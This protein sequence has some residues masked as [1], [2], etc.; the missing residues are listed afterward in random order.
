[1]SKILEVGEP[2]RRHR[3]RSVRCPDSRRSG[4][5]RSRPRRTAAIYMAKQ[6]KKQFPGSDPVLPRWRRADIRT[7][8]ARALQ[9]CCRRHQARCTRTSLRNHIIEAKTEGVATTAYNTTLSALSAVP[10]NAVVLMQAVNDEDLGGMYKAA[11]ARHVAD[12]IVNS[13]GGDS[14]GLSQ[15]CADPSTTSARGTSIRRA[16]ARCCSR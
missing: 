12:Y 7:G 8:G 2:L 4:W 13:F 14:Y 16:G 3:R 15:V 6:A 5:H 10:S 9:G 1:M 11:Q